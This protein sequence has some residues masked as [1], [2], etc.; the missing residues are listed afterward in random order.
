MRAQHEQSIGARVGGFDEVKK[1]GE[2]AETLRHLF[3]TDFDKPVVHP[4]TG[5]G[6]A[7]GQSLRAL[8]FMMR[9]GEI[10]PAAVKI[11]TIAEEIE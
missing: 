7:R 8:I 11:E 4:V 10:L 6:S 2:I 9:K 1:V 3:A 5:K